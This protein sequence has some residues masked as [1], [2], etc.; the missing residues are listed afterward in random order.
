MRNTFYLVSSVIWCVVCHLIIP[1]NTEA[2]V[3]LYVCN[4]NSKM[5]FNAIV[6]VNKRHLM[7]LNFNNIK[8]T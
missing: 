3:Y 1:E 2:T 4:C 7:N 8:N 6:T 5:H